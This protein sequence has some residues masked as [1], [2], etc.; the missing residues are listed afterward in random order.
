ML[1]TIL[2]KLALFLLATLLGLII[3]YLSPERPPEHMVKNDS[4]TETINSLQHIYGRTITPLENNTIEMSINLHYINRWRWNTIDFPIPSKHTR[5]IIITPETKMID[6]NSPLSRHFPLNTFPYSAEQYTTLY[7]KL[8]NQI[9]PRDIIPI[10][11]TTLHWDRGLTVIANAP[12]IY[13][14]TDPITA[15]IIIARD[16]NFQ[17]YRAVIVPI[18][19]PFL[20][21]VISLLGRG[22]VI[23]G[24][25][26]DSILRYAISFLLIFWFFI[27]SGIY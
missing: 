17:D 9:A 11:E 16:K 18:I 6:F 19:Y 13:S 21:I 15:K 1:N 10:T 24:V 25:P 2:Q 12:E 3:W 4:Y 20:I 26:L 5:K 27:T 7:Q 22:I 8:P 23:F 14:S